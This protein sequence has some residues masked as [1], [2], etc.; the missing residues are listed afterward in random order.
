MHTILFNQHSQAMQFIPQILF[1]MALSFTGYLA[2]R[3][4]LLIKK[5]IQSGKDD[6]RT[7]RP[8]ERL[9]NM[10]LLAFGQKKM[11]RKPVVGVLH[12]IVYAGFILINIEMLEIVLDGLLGTHRIFSQPLGSFYSFVLNFFEILAFGVLLAC[13]VFLVRRNVLKVERFQPA[14]H[15]EMKGW[16]FL[17][18]NIILTLEIVL[19]AAF[20]TMNAADYVLQTRDYGH[21][22]V[23]QTGSFAISRFIAP[24][25]DGLSDTAL[26]AVERFCWW[27]HIL[28]I[29]FFMVY[30]TYSK[31]LHIVL[32]FPNTYFGDLGPKGRMH[33]MPAVSEE[34]KIMLGIAQAPEN[35]AE[36]GRFGARDATDLSWK[37]LMDA[38]A[39]T[40][41]GRCTAVCPA[42]ITGKKLSPRKIM[43]DTRDRMEEVG[44]NRDKNKGFA[45]DG[46]S[47]LHDYITVEELRACTSCNAC[48][49]ACPVSINPLDII[50]DLRRNLVMEE[51][52]APQE[53]NMMFSNI[54]NNMAPWKFSPDDRDKWVAEMAD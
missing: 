31:H 5:T 45:D 13:A 1:L 14:R 7:D 44:R 11:F 10:L 32:A 18:A 28:G 26:F 43:M 36:V 46:K 54:E 52:N 4:V 37:S 21:F 27:F 48:V 2:G 34:V 42:N 15:R 25:I 17:D 41:C 40:E 8:Q 51:S 50:F 16:P 47:L 30:L 12:F 19:M 53:W 33:N 22:A 9:R 38:Y 39:C 29:M 23:V 49:E 24:L 6:N 20:L 3:R 35:P